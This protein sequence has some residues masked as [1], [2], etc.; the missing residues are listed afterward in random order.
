MRLYKI[1]DDHGVEHEYPSVTTVTGALPMAPGLK[2]FMEDFPNAE[3]YTSKRA[4]IG[5][6]SHFYFECLNSQKLDDHTPILEELDKRFIGKSTSKIIA[7]IGQKIEEFM[8]CHTFK[9][10]SLE[11]KVWSHEL[12]IAGRV[13]YIGY[14]DGK[15]SIIDLK[16]SRQFY[17]PDNGIDKH[18]I[19][20]SAYKKAVKDSKHLEIEKLYILRV[21]ENNHPEIKEKSD[22]LEGFIEARKL[23][24]EQRKI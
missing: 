15:L 7:N 19:Q 11:E 2:S 8:S 23:F 4:Y 9:P 16:T 5:T 1:V 24:F 10:V 6:M 17:P 20:L 14:F 21:N 22:D 13:D 18:S 3:E 12:K